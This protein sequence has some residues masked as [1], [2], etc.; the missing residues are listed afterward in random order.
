MRERLRRIALRVVKARNKTGLPL[1]EK[2]R[3][4]CHHSLLLSARPRAG[5]PR[6]AK[7]GASPYYG[8]GAR[9][10]G[11]RKT[12]TANATGRD[13][14]MCVSLFCPAPATAVVVLASARAFSPFSGCSRSAISSR[15]AAPA[16]RPGWAGSNPAL[17]AETSTHGLNDI[18]PRQH[19]AA[20]GE[21]AADN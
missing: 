14:S 3:L 21:I 18:S 11:E 10:S 1:F 2:R 19:N 13:L 17:P 8:A 9:P 5:E 7:K 15:Q 16:W 6:A 12:K 4:A 20:R